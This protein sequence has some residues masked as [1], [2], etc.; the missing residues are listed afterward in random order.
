[1]SEV[2]DQEFET[3]KSSGEIF[4][5]MTGP[6]EEEFVRMEWGN[7]RRSENKMQTAFE[8]LVKEGNRWTN[9]RFDR[10]FRCTDEG[11]KLISRI[12]DFETQQ[13]KHGLLFTQKKI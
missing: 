10:Q 8:T 3:Q 12:E 4:L 1:M 6:Q 2:K 9:Q 13:R 5:Y 7:L 11:M